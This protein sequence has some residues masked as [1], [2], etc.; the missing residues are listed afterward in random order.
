MWLPETQKI[1]LLLRENLTKIMKNN[2]SGNYQNQKIEVSALR[3]PRAVTR[4]TVYRALHIM[5]R[6]LF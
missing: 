3:V 2:V 4:L 5:E 6:Q 1:M